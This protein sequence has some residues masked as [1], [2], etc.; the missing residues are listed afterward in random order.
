MA[1]LSEHVC[2]VCESEVARDSQFPPWGDAWEPALMGTTSVLSGVLFSILA[3]VLPTAG[4]ATLVWWCDRY[5][6]EPI[7]LLI[8]TFLWGAFPAIILAIAVESLLGLPEAQ[9]GGGVSGSISAHNI[10][11]PIVEELAKGVALLMLLL[12]WQGEFDDVLDGILYGAMIGFGFAMTENFLYF[13]AALEEG[14]WQSWG[15][16]VVLRSIVFGLNH[17]FFTAFTGAG[18]GYAQMARTRRGRYGVPVIALLAAVASHAIHNL[19]VALSG[20]NPAAILLSLFSDLGGVVLV[21][22]MVWL[23]LRQEQQW[24]RIELA[25][26]IGGL[27]TAADYEMLISQKMRWQAT[28]GVWRSDGWRALRSLRQFQQCATELAFQRRRVRLQGTDPV[29]TRHI[30]KLEVS[31]NDTRLEF[32]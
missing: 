32:V 17:A 5:E 14:G 21:V 25:R 23:A 1:A 19:G 15:V 26:D 22:V 24:L 18:L 6:R 31:L 2:Q 29:S 7:P 11:A 16:L 13:V 12:F 30:A 4:W 10:W 28:L 3:A 9:L 8:A 27:L 20:S